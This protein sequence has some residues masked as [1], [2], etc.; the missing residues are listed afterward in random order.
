[1][2]EP[3][4]IDDSQSW[5]HSCFSGNQQGTVL[6]LPFDDKAQKNFARIHENLLGAFDD[7][8]LL[9]LRKLSSME[10]MDR[11][12][13][14]RVR[15]IRDSVSQENRGT[16]I[17]LKTE[18][19]AYSR[20]GA[21]VESYWYMKSTRFEPL[22]KRGKYSVESTEVSIAVRFLVNQESKAFFRSDE[23]QEDNN[24]KEADERFELSLDTSEPLYPLYAFL[25]TKTAIFRFVLQGDFLLPASREALHQDSSWNRHLLEKV[26]YSF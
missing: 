15:H 3:I 5:L 2:I 6:R 18:K 22:E 20:P 7:I 16:W 26:R 21:A 13:N 10:L 9:F 23:A 19:G 1:M 11:Q 12:N 4:F 17:S 24:S 14:S 25:P 8:L